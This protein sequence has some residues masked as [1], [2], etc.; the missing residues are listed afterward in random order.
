MTNGRKIVYTMMAALCLLMALF[1]LTACN[2]PSDEGFTVGELRTEPLSLHTVEVEWITG[3]CHVLVHDS[4]EL[5]VYEE[6]TETDADNRMRWKLENGKLTVRFCKPRLFGKTV[7]YDKT[8]YFYVPKSLLDGIENVTVDTVSADLTV[9][10][11]KVETMRLNTVSGDLTAEGLSCDEG[12]IASVSGDVMLTNGR[13]GTLTIGNTS[14]NVLLT[15]SDAIA[16]LSVSTISGNQAVSV[17]IGT[18]ELTLASVSGNITALIPD[19]LTFSLTC[20]SVSGTIEAEE[21]LRLAVLG[22]TFTR[23]EG[24]LKG[25]ITAVSGHI[26][27]KRLSLITPDE[28]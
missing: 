16:T 9:K 5:Y 17:P 21:S 18:R 6:T 13:T 11:L 19:D 8:L 20:E 4:E 3:D 10:G 22:D 1:S 7:E 24:A 15:A 23:G 28:P 2:M 27:L 14:G 12:E 25:E 26:T